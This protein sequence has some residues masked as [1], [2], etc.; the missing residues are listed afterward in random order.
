MNIYIYIQC[1]YMYIFILIYMYIIH[2]YTYMYIVGWL[3]GFYGISTFVGL[4]HKY[5]VYF[6]KAFLFQAI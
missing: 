2:I 5:I 6:S 3:I 1:I 4:V